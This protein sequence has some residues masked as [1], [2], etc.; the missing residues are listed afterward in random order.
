M[1]RNIFLFAFFGILALQAPQAWANGWQQVPQPAGSY[2]PYWHENAAAV[3]FK[4]AYW[5]IGT[6]TIHSYIL[7]SVDG[8][9]T[10]QKAV[11]TAPF[12]MRFG[13]RLLVF[14]NKLWLFGGAG[15]RTFTDFQLKND[16]WSTSDGIGWTRVVEH[17]SW[18]P[19]RD[20]AVIGFDGKIWLFGGSQA[21]GQNVSLDTN[22]TNDIW[23]SSNGKDWT[24]AV[25]AAKWSARSGH[26]V[27]YYNNRLFLIGGSNKNDVWRSGNGKDWELWAVNC[28]WMGRRGHASPIIDGKMWII[29]GGQYTFD[30]SSQGSSIGYSY[31]TT[32]DAWSSTDGEN[33]TKET[34]GNW[35][36]RYNFPWC[37][38]GSTFWAFP[39]PGNKTD[40]NTEI[41]KTSTGTAWTKAMWNFKN[42]LANY[43]TALVHNGKFWMFTSAIDKAAY[44]Q[45]TWSS[46]DA[47]NWTLRDQAA[48][49]STGTWYHNRPFSFG[50]LMW[51]TRDSIWLYTSSDA[52]QWT[53]V[54]TRLPAAGFIAKHGNQ[55]WLFEQALSPDHE[56]YTKVW[57]SSDSAKTW[58][59][60]LGYAERLIL[61]D[62]EASFN[63][64]MYSL[65]AKVRSSINGT[66]W[67]VDVKAAPWGSTT[68]IAAAVTGN[69]LWVV[70]AAAEVW[71]TAD[72]VNWVKNASTAP[73]APVSS[74]FFHILGY[75]G[76]LWYLSTMNIL[77]TYSMES[78]AGGTAWRY[79]TKNGVWG[80]ACLSYE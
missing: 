9:K 30:P 75:N 27:A 2:Y 14:N 52:K 51:E 37:M 59:P 11:E 32:G 58:T 55:L 71:S 68:P 63:G 12:G 20:H 4:N 8:C 53:K 25:A 60:K 49:V 16:V 56:V 40:F 50:G 6:N 21:S 15:S 1:R 43:N 41:W 67:R 23:Y 38:S 7:R 3:Y 48:T 42:P 79:D 62:I 47:S 46:P 36:A 31:T 34:A 78:N 19:R 72:G 64:R 35:S 66:D 57:I 18:S 5:I 45:A 74:K 33:W 70:S 76:S 73:W 54:E 10:W 13:H 80:K 26:Q 77:G 24:K 22:S 29:G 28:P 65:D 39:G 69:R 44:P 17:A 61:S